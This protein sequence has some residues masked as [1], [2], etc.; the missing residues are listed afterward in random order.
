MTPYSTEDLCKGIGAFEQEMRTQD[1]IPGIAKAIPVG[2]AIG[3][4]FSMMRSGLSATKIEQLIETAFAAN[5]PRLKQILAMYEGDCWDIH[6]WNLLPNG[7][8]KLC[9]ELCQQVRPDWRYDRN[10]SGGDW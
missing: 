1:A 4:L 5:A 3:I 7:Q 8:Y 9:T 6:L 2:V 10:S